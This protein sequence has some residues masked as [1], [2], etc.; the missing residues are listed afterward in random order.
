MGLRGSSSSNSI[1]AHDDDIDDDDEDDEGGEDDTARLGSVNDSGSTSKNNATQNA[2]TLQRVKSLSERNRMA[3]NKL[4]SISRM[5]SPISRPSSSNAPSSASVASNRHSHSGSET[6]RESVTSTPNHQ[7]RDTL[8]RNSTLRHRS[9]TITPPLPMR[10]RLVSAPASPGK[11]LGSVRNNTARKRVSMV[12]Y[13]AFDDDD[14]SDQ[15]SVRSFRRTTGSTSNSPT[16]FLS[17][18]ARRRNPLPRE[19]TEANGKVRI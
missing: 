19:F 11:A 10:S 5:S 13:T 9:G 4:S 17:P 8:T 12:S 15:E 7:T 14:L 1:P 3:L 18:G 2:A 16:N 6:E